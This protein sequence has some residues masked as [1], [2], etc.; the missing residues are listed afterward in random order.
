M[1]RY[2]RVTRFY[3][4]TNKNKGGKYMLRYI[5]SVLLLVLILSTSATSMIFRNPEELIE[6]FFRNWKIQNQ[7]YME[8]SMVAG[9]L[10]NFG[11]LMSK[12]YLMD[13]TID[14]SDNYKNITIVKIKTKLKSVEYGLQKRNFYFY[15]AKIT[16]SWQML[17][18]YQIERNLSTKE[19][20]D[21]FMWINRI[22]QRG[23]L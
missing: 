3:S 2:I 20:Y 8:N 11:K 22:Y 15:F 19:A 23:S 14:W 6:Q 9:N 16:G 1:N 10:T 18:G 21:F 17:N 4:N 7:T 5:T 12:Q 13:Y